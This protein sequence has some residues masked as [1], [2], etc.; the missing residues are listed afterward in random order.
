MLD[1]D[2]LLCVLAAVCYV[3]GIRLRRGL[4]EFFSY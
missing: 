2:I 1:W 3:S 4:N